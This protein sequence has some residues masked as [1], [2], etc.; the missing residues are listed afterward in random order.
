M[1]AYIA[2]VHRI[3]VDDGAK[4]HARQLVLHRPDN[5]LAIAPLVAGQEELTGPG[6]SRP[7]PLPVQGR[8][9]ACKQKSS[10]VG[11]ILAVQ[12]LRIVSPLFL[13][14]GTWENV[15]RRT[16]TVLHLSKPV[17]ACLHLAH[18]RPELF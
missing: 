9:A 12:I 15:W 7:D 4:R 6:S 18:S 14:G 11:T 8:T 3:R 13:K 1:R 16:W 5:A 17:A 10:K 2:V